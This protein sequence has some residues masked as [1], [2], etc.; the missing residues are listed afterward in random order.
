MIHKNK[1]PLI[2]T[3]KEKCRVCYSCV[4]ECPAH[5]IRIEGGQ[6]EVIIDRCIGC[7]N[8]VRV[9]TQKAKKVRS[10]IN[11]VEKILSSK[12]KSAAAIAPTFPAEFTDVSYKRV[13]GILKALGFDYVVEVAFGADL[14]SNHYREIVQKE[15][16]HYIGSTCPA[17]VAYVEKYYPQLRNNL[18]PVDSPMI[19]TAKV[20]HQLY[21]K[22]TDI[23]FIGPCLAKKDESDRS[24]DIAEAI[25]FIELRGL[26]KKNDISL[27]DVTPEDF[28]PP[29]PGKGALYPI[30]KGI[31]QSANL[32]ENLMNTNIIATDGTKQ[33]VQAIKD[34]SSEVE[35]VKFL[36]L[37]SCNGCIMGPGMTTKLTQFNRRGYISN[38]TQYRYSNLNKVEWEKDIASFDN[39]NLTREFHEDDQRQLAPDRRELEPILIKMGKYDVEDELNCGA[40]GYSTCVEHAVAIHRGLAENEMCL[41]YTIDTLRAT[42]YELKN[43]YE[44]L[45]NAKKALVQSEKLAS[46]GRLASGI[47]HEI[48]NPLTGILTFSSLLL[49]DLEK[50]KYKDDISTIV[51]ETKRCRDIVRGLLDFARESKPEKELLNMNKIITETITILKKHVNFQNITITL[52]LDSNMPDSGMDKNQMRS[53]INNLAI[54]A[55]DAMLEGGVLSIKSLFIDNTIIVEISDTGIGIDEETLN[56]IFD[57]FFTTKETGKGTGLGLAVIYGIVDRHRGNIEVK[58]KVNKGTTFTMKMPLYGMQ[59]II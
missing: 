46:L 17:V 6:A 31:L 25:T 41:P 43:S 1:I 32:E 42:T 56:K 34:F 12:K 47:A 50:S 23:V 59:Q 26:L 16:S 37:L 36:E 35:N 28:D 9:C 53:V 38:Y 19:V 44:D 24:N 7:G 30:G 48:N 18:M 10:S 3:I 4:R 22:D 21:G 5:A 33:F 2:Q 58:S 54:N 49:E 13:V 27:H 11:E 51:D 20:I 57:P 40:C 29:H 52:N 15:D 45:I 55:A 8:C 14:V 39:L